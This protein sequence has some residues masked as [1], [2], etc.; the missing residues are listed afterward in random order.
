MT[1]VTNA[2]RSMLMNLETLE[3]DPVL[4]EFVILASPLDTK[5]FNH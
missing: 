2:S 3:W 1:D 5:P 4:C